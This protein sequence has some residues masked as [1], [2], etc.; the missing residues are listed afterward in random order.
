MRALLIPCLLVSLVASCAATQHTH[1]KDATIEALQAEVEKERQLL[2]ETRA[3]LQ[4]LV[5]Q[6]EPLLQMVALLKVDPLNV[7]PNPFE[8]A[9]SATSDA[10]DTGTSEDADAFAARLEAGVEKLS[11]KRYRLSRNLLDELLANPTLLSRSA[12]LVPSYKDGK[13]QG[14]KLFAIRPSSI[15]ASLGFKN[16]DTL[17]RINGHELSSPDKAL[18]VYTKIRDA[19]KIECDLVRRGKPLVHTI[20]IK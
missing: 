6:L 15:L 7:A 12:R 1:P 5:G 8:E 11:E 2:R 20:L 4:T 10:S 14:F 13:A 3:E 19:N 9:G 16:G 17:A 18:E